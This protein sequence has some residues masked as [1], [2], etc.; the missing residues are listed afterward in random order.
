MAGPDMFKTTIVVN[1]FTAYSFFPYFK[2]L[3]IFLSIC[4]EKHKFLLEKLE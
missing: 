1:I 3:K 2:A 4:F